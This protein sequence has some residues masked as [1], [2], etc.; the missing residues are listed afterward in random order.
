MSLVEDEDVQRTGI[1]H[2]QYNVTGKGSAPG[3]TSAAK[4][5]D[6]DDGDDDGNSSSPFPSSLFKDLCTHGPSFLEALPI[7]IVAVHHCY[8]VSTAQADMDV[9]R[10]IGRDLRCRIREHYGTF[11]SVVSFYF[12][13]SREKETAT[14]GSLL[15]AAIA[16]YKCS[17]AQEGILPSASTSPGGYFLR[18]WAGTD[19]LAIWL[20]ATEAAATATKR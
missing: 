11:T 15:S 20:G 16:G 3:A 13:N 6:D 1:V 14:N 5:M 9:Y 2:I 19:A 17:S 18:S 8:D 7:R 4:E 10:V 12:S